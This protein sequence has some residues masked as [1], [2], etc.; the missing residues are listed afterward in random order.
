VT[1]GKLSAISG[2][3]GLLIRRA[4]VIELGKITGHFSEYGETGNVSGNVSPGPSGNGEEIPDASVVRVDT[5][6]QL[7]IIRDTLLR[8][9]IE[10]N[11]RQQ[12]LIT[13]QSETIGYLRAGLDQAGLRLAEQADAVAQLTAEREQARLHSI[14]VEHEREQLEAAREHAQRQAEIIA[15]EREAVEAERD[16]LQSRVRALEVSQVVTPDEL[17][18]AQLERSHRSWWRFWKE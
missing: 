17:E 11:E 6:R 1:T 7:E 13:G 9:L 12:A 15:L 5:E 10:Q 18:N 2:K 8:P 3:R 4:D 16:A 14:T